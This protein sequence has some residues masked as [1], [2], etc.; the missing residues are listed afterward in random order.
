[1]NSAA[2][3]GPITKPLMPKSAMP[4]MVDINTM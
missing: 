2:I 3:T 4:P 1:M